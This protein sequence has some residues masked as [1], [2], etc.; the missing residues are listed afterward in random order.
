M[1]ITD[2]F[3]KRDSFLHWFLICALT[4][5]KLTNEI[6]QKPYNLT[7]TWNGVDINC[8]RAISR[9]EDQFDDLVEKKAKKMIED[10]KYDIMEPFHDKIDSMTEEI[11]TL[12]KERL[13]LRDIK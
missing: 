6:K 11:D 8:I 13:T 4:G 3:E 1:D 5:T 9:L 7:M 10:M 12:I 2:D